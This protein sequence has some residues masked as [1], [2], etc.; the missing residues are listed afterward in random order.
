MIWVLVDGQKKA[1]Y[2]KLIPNLFCRFSNWARLVL[3]SHSTSLLT[4][5]LFSS[6]QRLSPLPRRACLSPWLCQ[7]PLLTLFAPFLFLP[8]RS[9]LPALSL[10]GYYCVSVLLPSNHFPP[11]NNRTSYLDCDPLQGAGDLSLFPLVHLL[12]MLK[13]PLELVFLPTQQSPSA[14]TEPAIAQGQGVGN[15]RLSW[16]WDQRAAEAWG[17]PAGRTSLISDRVIIMN[18][19]L[20]CPWSPVAGGFSFIY[21]VLAIKTDIYRHTY[22]HIPGHRPGEVEGVDTA[23]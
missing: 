16:L 11:P 5:F 19:M 13:G 22:I 12:L 18:V 10:S 3:Y 7:P 6:G 23:G 21:L 4:L 17:G 2:R 15:Y 20:G 14:F 8:E 9:S 1:R